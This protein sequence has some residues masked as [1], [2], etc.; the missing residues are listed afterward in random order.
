[1]IS[2][3]VL[4]EQISLLRK[5]LAKWANTLET[6]LPSVELPAPEERL[7][8]LLTEL[9]SELRLCGDLCHSVAA[10]LADD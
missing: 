2:P 1:M 8:K 3:D 9:Q 7:V 6:G 10:H 4:R 5:I